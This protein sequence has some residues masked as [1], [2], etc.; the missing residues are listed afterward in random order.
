MYDE[1]N[2]KI[3]R[4]KANQKAVERMCRY[5]LTCRKWLWVMV[6]LYFIMIFCSFKEETKIFITQWELLRFRIKQFT[7]EHIEELNRF[8]LLLLLLLWIFTLLFSIS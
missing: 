3:I 2:I 4:K 8:H 1:Y 5:I 7:N 6:F